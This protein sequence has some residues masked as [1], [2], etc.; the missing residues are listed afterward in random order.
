VMSR[1]T[2]IGSLVCGAI[3]VCFAVVAV[4]CGAISFHKLSDKA[5]TSAGL[6]SIYVSF[7]LLIKKLSLVGMQLP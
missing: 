7:Y 6:W 2:A 3:M 5:A 1:N 4:I